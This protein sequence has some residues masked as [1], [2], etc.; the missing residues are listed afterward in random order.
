M[1]T[2][3]YEATAHKFIET[4]HS[5]RTGNGIKYVRWSNNFGLTVLQYVIEFL[6]VFGLAVNML[7]Q[8]ATQLLLR[9]LKLLFT[10]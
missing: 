1:R 6:T 3:K 5:T 7:P 4:L 9:G 2:A 8:S 10:L